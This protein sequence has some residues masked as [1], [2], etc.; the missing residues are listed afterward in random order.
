[1]HRKIVCAELSREKSYYWLSSLVVPRPIAWVTTL[2][3][4]QEVNLAPFSSFN[5]VAHDPCLIAININRKQDGSH[6]DTARNLVR[7]R[8]AVIQMA[9]KSHVRELDLSS[10]EFDPSQSEVKALGLSTRSSALIRTPRL[11]SGSIQLE[12]KLDQ[13]IPLGNGVNELFI[14]EVLCFHV[15]ERILQ[16]DKLIHSHYQPLCRVSGPYYAV[17]EQTFQV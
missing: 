2:S 10:R 13:V 16:G 11:E 7:E 8:E 6:K 1:M 3:E 5:Y 4:N 9:E 12:C 14:L 15:D 17:V